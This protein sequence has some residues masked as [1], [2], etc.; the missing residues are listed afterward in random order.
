MPPKGRRALKQDSLVKKCQPNRKKPIKIKE[1]ILRAY[2]SIF[3][4]DCVLDF[5]EAA[6]ERDEFFEAYKKKHSGT[7]TN[8]LLEMFQPKNTNKIEGASKSAAGT[9]TQIF[10]E[11]KIEIEKDGGGCCIF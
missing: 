6:T 9:A 2:K 5:S 8:S 7:D 1:K 11:E 10:T 3:G 4:C